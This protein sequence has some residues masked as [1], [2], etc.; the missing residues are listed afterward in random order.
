[1]QIFK[2]FQFILQLRLLSN[3][4]RETLIQQ[5]GIVE[6]GESKSWILYMQQML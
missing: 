3:F 5:N 2:I 4:C 6:T 1:M